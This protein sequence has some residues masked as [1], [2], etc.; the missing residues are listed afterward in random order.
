MPIPPSRMGHSSFKSL[1]IVLMY[2]IVYLSYYFMAKV[3]EM[4]TRLV[5]SWYLVSDCSLHKSAEQQVIIPPIYESCIR[6]PAW[7]RFK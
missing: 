1:N 2:Y 7:E 4:D 6:E 3:H 5:C